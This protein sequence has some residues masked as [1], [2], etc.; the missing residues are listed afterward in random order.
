MIS[1]IN[2]K[3]ADLGWVPIHFFYR[4]IPRAE[5]IAFYRA[6]QIALVTPLKDGMNLVAKEFCAAR[7]DK[8]G[9]LVLSEFAG[10]ACE[11]KHHALVVNPHDTE[12][13][14]S[15]LYTALRMED[16]EQKMRMESMRSHLCRHDVF[17]WART[18]TD[19]A[20][21]AQWN[22]RIVGNFA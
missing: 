5:L 1:Q 8:R 7:V 9:V 16:T 17:R 22:N 4:S 11:L 2:G 14:A 20:I 19:D 18:F 6:A 21:P 15:V 10:A 12:R 3:Y 13:M